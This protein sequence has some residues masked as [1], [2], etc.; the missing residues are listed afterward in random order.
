M[1]TITL[2][3]VNT[4]NTA[5]DGTGDSPRSGA[6]KINGN[7][8]TIQ[9]FLNA[10][11]AL[12]HLSP[13][14]GLVVEQDGTVTVDGL[15][16]SQIATQTPLNGATRLVGADSADNLL[17]PT[18][19]AL[20]V[21]ITSQ[22]TNL[23]TAT[24]VSSS[25]SGDQVLVVRNGAVV[26]LPTSALGSGTSSG[27]GTTPS[28]AATFTVAASPSSVA[29]GQAI[30][31]TVTPGPGGWQSGEVVTPSAAGIAGSFDQA[32]K[33]GSGTNAVV[34]VFT[35]SAPGSGTL[36]ASAPNM[37]LSGAAAAITATAATGGGTPPSGSMT[38]TGATYTDRG[39][40]SGKKMLTGGTGVVP[41]PSAVTL[42]GYFTVKA[43]FKYGATPPASAV[44]IRISNTAGHFMELVIA[45]SQLGAVTDY[46]NA[47]SAGSVAANA[48][49]ELAISPQG[50]Y[51]LAYADGS[52]QVE[53]SISPTFDLTGAQVS[54]DASQFTGGIYSLQIVN[55][56]FTNQTA[57]I[58]TFEFDGSGAVS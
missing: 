14:T 56:E 34:F 6:L 32:T 54:V 17:N 36:S 40:G 16:V 29:V 38:M 4:G 12:A 3:L 22:A 7:A 5:N 30:N 39:D 35:S 43:K 53:G 20:Q 1:A 51:I 9:A 58:A 42:G 31:L 10:L 19:T 15:L 33:T 49:H 57:V 55:Y 21:W 46:Y 37:T 41:M 52:R 23:T 48:V 11:G 8:A 24:A 28:T 44:V 25:I 45:G 13:G 18:L 27:G 47:P 2:Q 50:T 26:L